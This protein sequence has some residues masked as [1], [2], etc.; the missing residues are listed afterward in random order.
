MDCVA[1]FTQDKENLPCSTV[2]VQEEERLTCK[3]IARLTLQPNDVLTARGC[4]PRSLK[5]F[6]KDCVR[7][8]RGRSS[9][10]TTHVRTLDRSS[11]LAWKADT[12]RDDIPKHL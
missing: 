2:H 12:Q 6:E 8:I 3:H 9:A 10:T 4:R 5:S 7:A 1:Q 11:P